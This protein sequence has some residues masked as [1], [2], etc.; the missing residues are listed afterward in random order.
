MLIMPQLAC[1]AGRERFRGGA[2]MPAIRVFCLRDAPGP[3]VVKP[4]RLLRARTVLTQPL[5]RHVKPVHSF[6]ALDN[7][8]DPDPERWQG[9]PVHDLLRGLAVD[10]LSAARAVRDPDTGVEQPGI[11]R[12]QVALWADRSGLLG[13]SRITAMSVP[14]TTLRLMA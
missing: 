13:A 2:L 14:M 8:E 4:V 7:P 11:V 1:L 12:P 10:L 3:P 5:K 6:L 9:D